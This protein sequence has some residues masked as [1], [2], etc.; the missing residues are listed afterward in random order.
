ML[1]PNR[2]ISHQIFLIIIFTFFVSSLL[3]FGQK[4]A[5]NQNGIKK[6][7]EV[8]DTYA[9]DVN[10]FY[11]PFDNKGII[12]DI[13]LN[14]GL[15]VG[16]RLNGMDGTV[17]LFSSGFLLSGFDDANDDGIPQDSEIWSNGI[18]SVGRI[19]D[20]HPG[21]VGSDSGDIKNKIYL[22]KKMDLSFGQSWQDWSD[23]VALGADFY[24]GNGDGSYNP[25]D[26][27]GN[28]SWDANEDRPSLIGDITAW[29]VYNDAVP[30]EQ[31]IFS[32]DPQEIEI[33]QTLFAF[34]SLTGAVS[35]MIFIRY[36]IE[37]IAG[38]AN[39]YDSVYFSTIADADIGDYL[40]DLIGSDTLGHGGYTFNAG[41]DAE[42]G[43]NPPAFLIGQLQGPVV[44]IPGE[45]YIDNNNDGEFT[46]GIDTPLQ[47][48]VIRRGKYSDTEYISGAKNLNP[49]SVTQFMSSHPTHGAPETHLQ[50]RNYLKGGQGA[51][52]DPLDPCLWS[53]GNGS[54]LSNCSELNPNFLYSGD[55]VTGVGWLNTTAFDQLFMLA[56]GPFK[57][58][59]GKPIELIYAYIVGRGEDPKSSITKSK[60]YLHYA[61]LLYDANFDPMLVDIIEDDNLV[62]NDFQLYQNY[63]NPFNPTTTIKY[64]IPINVKG[65]MANVK[66]IVF[67]I[68][69]RE[70]TTLVNEQ[71]PA[72]TY[73]VQFDESSVSRRIS[74]GVYFYSLQY[75]EFRETKKLMLL[76]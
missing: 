25:I 6:K 42:F 20:Y 7:T 19:I 51:L 44:F 54:S 48:A 22:V 11:L 63:P 13:D 49:T 60:E 70:I 34:Q 9:F 16:G 18:S 74:S 10:N 71:K 28:G 46:S 68:L 27:N 72:G 31:R 8:S 17:F 30:K 38:I 62:V 73:Q 36:E 33:K 47:S 15:Q 57:L 58:E 3:L 29:S 56:T 50:L 52:G 66:I 55:P 39:E 53:F 26:L 2:F 41:P 65:Q 5:A 59:E 40:D 67:D 4:N 21:P 69:G 64:Q 43:P 45:T 37:N 24:D 23:A 75:G 61:Q 1:I 35:N 76:K 12:A 32:Q 14:S